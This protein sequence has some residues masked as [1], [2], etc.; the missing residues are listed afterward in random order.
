LL[1][2]SGNTSVAVAGL[3]D[4]VELDEPGAVGGAGA[5]AAVGL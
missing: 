4:V 3:L 1:S 5:G 2:T